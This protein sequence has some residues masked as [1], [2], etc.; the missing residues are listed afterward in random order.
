MT[1]ATISPSREHQAV[2]GQHFTDMDERVTHT[3]SPNFMLLNTNPDFV[4][5]RFFVGGFL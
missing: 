5:K 2:P 3:I 4:S 1:A